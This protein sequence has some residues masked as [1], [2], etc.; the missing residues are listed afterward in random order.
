MHTADQNTYQSVPYRY[1]LVLLSVLLYDAT[2]MP[3]SS[4]NRDLNR[5]SD[6]KFKKIA[7]LST[8]AK[9]CGGY[10]T[11]ADLSYLLGIHCTAIS[12]T[13]KANPK[14]VVPLRG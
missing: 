11:Y 6:I 9:Q 10:L 5:V 2:D 8:Q 3:D 1:L 14:V 12:N 4:I 7:R 13:V